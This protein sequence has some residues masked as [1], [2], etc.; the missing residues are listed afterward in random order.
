VGLAEHFE[1]VVATDASA[2]QI[3]HAIRDSRIEYRVAR[4]EAGGLPDGSADLVT[5][6]QALHWVDV[7][8]FWRE[9]RR[10]ARPGGVIAAWG[11][12]LPVIEPAVDVV[13]DELSNGTLAAYWPPERRILDARYA[14]IDFPFVPIAAPTFT[15]EVEATLGEFLD[16]LRTWSAVRRWMERHDGDPVADVAPRLAP[17]WPGRRRIVWTLA[18]RAG[19]VDAGTEE[20]RS[21]LPTGAPPVPGGATP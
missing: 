6:A 8:R 2:G 16:Y 11:Y 4:A 14:T 15:M 19:R 21:S 20:R 10:V 3:S 1:R 7:P 5:I 12:V 9:V 13:I 17:H 18:L